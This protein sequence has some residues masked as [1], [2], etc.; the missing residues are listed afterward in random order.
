M[1][2]E[3]VFYESGGLMLEGLYAPSP[4]TRGVVVAHPHPLMGG[5][6]RDNVVMALVAVF[7][8]NRYSTLRFNFRG[9][10]R[11]EGIFDDGVGEVE[12]LKASMAC[13]SGQGVSGM[14]VAGYSFGALMA[15]KH[16][17]NDWNIAL[18]VLVSPPTDGPVIDGAR[19]RGTRGFMVC[20]DRDPFCRIDVLQQ[21]A[22]KAG[23]DLAVIPGADHFYFG[24]EMKLMESIGARLQEG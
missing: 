14:A 13:L 24:Y 18:T 19:F 6:M 10:G 8:Q 7:Q 21:E 1:R 3:R 12:V 2:E 17:L 16:L 4:G 20:G 5:S 9:V 22:G 15:A 11:S 23:W